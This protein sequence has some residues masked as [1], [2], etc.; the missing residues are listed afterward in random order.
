LAR[1]S[2]LFNALPSRMA[3]IVAQTVDRSRWGGRAKG[4][5]RRPPE[6]RGDRPQRQDCRQSRAQ[7][8]AGRTLY[9]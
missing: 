2:L 4:R 6:R 3:K 9:G 7:R 1:I 5:G 8:A